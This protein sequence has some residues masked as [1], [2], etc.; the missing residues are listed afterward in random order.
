MT[1]ATIG[2][3]GECEANIFIVQFIA[4]RDKS[5]KENKPIN[6]CKANDN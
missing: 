4:K 6:K 5:G 2:S 3:F 1:V